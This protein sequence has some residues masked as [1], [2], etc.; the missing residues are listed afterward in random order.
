MG[1][2]G[3]IFNFIG[4]VARWIYGTLW[5]TIAHKQKFT[6]Q[7][8]LY[9]PNNS[10][11]WFDFAGHSLNNRIIGAMVLFTLCSLFI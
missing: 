7:E 3:I 1:L 6:F 4:A 5:R 11:D 2:G 8:Y 9:G 10:D